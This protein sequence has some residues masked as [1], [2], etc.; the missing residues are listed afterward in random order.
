MKVHLCAAD[1]AR[2]MG[3]IPRRRP[4]HVVRNDERVVE[5]RLGCGCV[6]EIDYDDPSLAAAL[7][8]SIEL[9]IKKSA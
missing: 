2:V 6:C 7:E 3:R 5:V 1:R 8:K 4:V 9:K